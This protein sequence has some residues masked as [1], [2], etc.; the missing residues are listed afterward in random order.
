MYTQG[1]PIVGGRE[2]A[3]IYP[4]VPG[5]TMDRAPDLVT[6]VTGDREHNPHLCQLEGE[7]HGKKRKRG[8][9][10]KE[11]KKTRIERGGGG[12]GGGGGS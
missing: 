6:M 7:G 8:K 3:N 9:K 10:D 5:L 4:L 12:G 2:A 11:K 1:G